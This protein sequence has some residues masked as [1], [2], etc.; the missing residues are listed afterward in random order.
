MT[1]V[2]GFLLL[3]LLNGL[4]VL[5]LLLLLSMLLL[6]LMQLLLLTLVLLLLLLLQTWSF[7]EAAQKKAAVNIQPLAR[8]TVLCLRFA[9][10]S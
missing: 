8:R 6:L 9:W 4:W 1:L 5:L 10:A 7:I 3:R 2:L